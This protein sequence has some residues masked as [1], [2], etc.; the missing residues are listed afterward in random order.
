MATT[1]CS[2]P[3]QSVQ[4]LSAC[5]CGAVA[6]L[7]AQ[8]PSSS[9]P[10]GTRPGPASPYQASNAQIAPPEVP[11][12]PTSS[13]RASASCPSSRLSTPAVNAV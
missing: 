4:L 7:S 6:A 2:A 12:R 1:F 5:S 10:A 9:S 11:L 3:D 13:Y 8:N